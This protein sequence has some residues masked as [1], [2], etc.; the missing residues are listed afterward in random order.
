M[1]RL[2]PVI[3][4]L[5]AMAA[6]ALTASPA[7]AKPRITELPL[8]AE[9]ALPN[10]IASGPD[11]A[12]WVTDSSLGRV[13]RITTNGKITSQDLGE[14]PSGIVSAGGALWIA[15]ASGDQIVRLATDGTQTPYA[16]DSGAFPTSI[17]E[18]PDGALW[19]TETRGDKIGR[20][21]ADGTITEYPLPTAGAFAT[22]ITVGP[23]GALWFSE[24]LGDKVGRVTTAGVVT[25]FGL[26]YAEPLPG[27]IV[28][29]DG[30]LFVALRNTNILAKL[31][32][33]GEV[34][35]ELPLATENAN[36]V[37][38]VL[39]PD[40]ALWISEHSAN[41]IARMTLDGTVTRE[42][43][44]PSGGPGSLA[45]GPDGA[46]WIA[47]E[48]VGQVARLD[49]G[50]DPPVD[51]HGTT[52]SAKVEQSVNPVVATFTDA[53]PNARARD[54]SVAISWGDGQTSA[55]TVTRATDGSF[56][57]RG[58]HTYFK[59]G[60]R[61][62]VVRITDGVGKGLDAKVISQAIVTA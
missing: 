15:D 2:R 53:D 12:L 34:I 28:A 45:F 46:L 36:P 54:Y 17:V 3:L 6:L 52:F 14:M 1:P 44:V 50:F 7:L 11:G 30:A 49:I 62:V 26:P 4:L 9:F 20:L 40:G 39:G 57:V 19:F 43:K 27:P 59:K 16:L 61:K 31:N 18:G 51:A 60:A 32:T 21:A 23:D 29:A 47:E 55:G 41:R 25:E 13:W 58:R 42:F 35:G 38:M 56:V 10:S 24:E 33:A 22:D 37:D 48:N 8:P 5:A